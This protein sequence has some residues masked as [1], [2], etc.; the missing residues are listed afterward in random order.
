[1]NQKPATFFRHKPLWLYWSA[2]FC[3]VFALG[4]GFMTA[5]A[6]SDPQSS[7]PQGWSQGSLFLFGLGGFLLC[8]AAAVHFWGQA[9]YT[10]L[11]I[12][13]HG[14][15]YHAPGYSLFASWA[16]VESIKRLPKSHIGEGLV[17]RSS[18]VDY[19]NPQLL[20]KL[21]PPLDQYI[22]LLPFGWK[23]EEE[24]LGKLLKDHRPGLF[25][26]RNR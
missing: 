26:P 12:A 2:S 23:W 18:K 4:A 10:R 9:R 5:S 16:E 17:L 8:I 1:M 6:L 11:V 3:L 13:P 15:E 20:N 19:N 24:Q 7:N 25:E 21:Q 14:I 22:P